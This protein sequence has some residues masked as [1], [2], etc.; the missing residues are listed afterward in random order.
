MVPLLHAM[1][2]CSH[3]F[4][5]DLPGSIRLLTSAGAHIDSTCV[6]P[7]GNTRTAL[8]WACETT[9]CCSGPV[10][11]L[12]AAGADVNL[13]SVTDGATA[14]ALAAARVNPAAV[15]QL[16]RHG[17]DPFV[18]KQRTSDATYHAAGMGSTQVLE[19]LMNH[20]PA[21]FH[22]STPLV[23]AADHGQL[24]CAKW[25][26]ARGVQINAA[27]HEGW[28]ALHSAA[29]S[30][31]NSERMLEL[32]LASG[33]AVNACNSGGDAPLHAL[34][35]TTGSVPC[36]RLLLAA[37]ADTAHTNAAGA[38]ALHAAMQLG[39][40]EL[41]QL[42]LKHNAAV[43]LNLR[44]PLSC[45]C[46]R[47]ATPIAAC[48]HPAVT[49]LLLAAGA[50]VHIRSSTGNTCLHVAVLHNHSAPC[51][52]LLIKAGADIAAVNAA[53]HTAAQIARN[54]GNELLAALLDRAAA[55]QK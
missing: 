31:D 33:A 43:L 50:D 34:A 55:Q 12:L 6:N 26:L 38:G 23:G 5:K 30:T 48:R 24:E 45:Q 13:A 46:C 7:G 39:N 37:G 19:L 53:G 36:A 8:M 42:L 54:K 21:M 32:L 2:L 35:S 4:H 14:V 41:V 9:Q 1:C 20:N 29:S 49:K 11:A 44:A 3:Q 17:A 51:V 27:D 25:L 18:V 15:R 16:L 40:T 22:S 47:L 10:E 28:T 52:C